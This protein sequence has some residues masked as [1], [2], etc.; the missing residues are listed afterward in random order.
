MPVEKIVYQDRIVY[1][2][3]EVIKEV[4]DNKCQQELELLNSQCIASMESLGNRCIDLLDQSKITIKGYYDLTVRLQDD[5][6]KLATP[7]YTPLYIPEPSYIHC[8][9]MTSS[10]F[11][12]GYLD[13][14]SY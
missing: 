2:E 12:V 1:Q 9:Y 6:S 10:N 13:C 3:V 5:I 14:S 8:Y 7:Y 4:T 11:V